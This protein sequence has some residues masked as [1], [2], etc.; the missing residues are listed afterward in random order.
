MR[1]EG[2]G[3]FR[4]PS[5]RHSKAELRRLKKGLSTISD[6][7]GKLFP[8]LRPPLIHVG[9]I[10]VKDISLP[11]LAARLRKKVGLWTRGGGSAKRN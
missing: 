4:F 8:F 10:L 9:V 7:E 2:G 1:D 6:T 3:L 5:S 11:V